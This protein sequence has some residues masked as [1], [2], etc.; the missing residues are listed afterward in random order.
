MN[1]SNECIKYVELIE[2]F[3][4]TPYKDCVGVWTI[5]FGMTGPEIKGLTYVTRPQ[6]E[7]MLIS[8]INKNYASVISVDLFKKVVFLKQNEFDAIVSMSYNI[9]TEG[10]LGSTLY[11]NI[12]A[13]VRDRATIVKNFQ[14]WCHGIIDG[15][16]QVID[17]LLRRRTEEAEMFLTGTATTSAATTTATQPQTKIVYT[18]KYLQHELN[19]QFNA[20]LVEDN[21]AGPKTLRKCPLCKF[22]AKGNITRWIQ[23]RVDVNADTYYGNDTLIAVQNYQKKHNLQPD[24]ICG[25]NTYKSLLN[26]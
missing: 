8:L 26:L 24:G 2:G 10:L 15:K 21:I 11:R 5:G 23:S 13:G 7:T 17:G 16:M 1:V 12:V 22:G 14:S 25:E 3:S 18:V 9:G 6:A 19:V 20:G 4:A